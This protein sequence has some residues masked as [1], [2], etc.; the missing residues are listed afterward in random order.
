MK[1]ILL[2][3]TIILISS[4][5]QLYAQDDLVP[6]FPGAGGHGKY[7]T[8][9]RGGSIYYVTTLE[10]NNN[11]GS[12]RYGV[13]TLSGKRTILFKVSGNIVLKSSLRITKGDVT[14]AGQSAP[15]DGICISGFPVSVS[16]DNVIIRY[17]RFRMGD[18]VIPENQA[19]G[20]DAL[21]GRSCQNV[22]IDHCS[23]SWCIDECASFYQNRDFTM[24]WCLVTESMRMSKH[25]KGP[26]GY[27]GIWGGTRASF[28]HNMMAHHD[29]RNPRFGPGIS[30]DP[31]PYTEIT[32][33]R[34]NVLYNWRGN[35]A[36]GGEGMAVNM[37]NNYHKPGPATPTGSKRGR[38]VSIDKS[39]DS[40]K[41]IYDVWG[42]FYIEGNVID[43]G[44]NDKNCINA[45]NDNWT[46]GVYN[47]IASG[48]GT[49]T[50]TDKAEMKATEPYPAGEVITHTAIKAYEKVLDY[51]GASYKRDE[52]DARIIKETR[53]GTTTFKGS[54]LNQP[55]IIDSQRDLKPAGAGDDWSAWPE[56]L[57]GEVPLDSDGDGIP[58]EWE[59]ANGLNP[60]NSADAKKT[61]EEGYTYL[62]VYLNSIVEEITTKQ[63][64]D[65]IDPPTS[66]K[67]VKDD[68]SSVLVSF[69]KLSKTLTVS[70]DQ[71]IT[72]IYIWNVTGSL[73]KKDIYNDSFC[74]MD[75][76][77][78]QPGSYIIKTF[79][80]GKQIQIASKIII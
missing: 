8:G 39:S 54:S 46:Y 41:K 75:L 42:R 25:S 14:I 35:A 58:N 55:G 9:G 7:T 33:M 68:K 10:D 16:A 36:Y 67:L 18:E 15:G 20:A 44:K 52:I 13:S 26:H 51:V 79:L 66:I 24:Q 3:V 30:D 57:Q 4:A 47:Q 63:Y 43:D 50:A 65:A 19:D 1:Q 64:E 32:D 48:Y 61:N 72:E 12:L 2:F 62:E 38:I 28:H 70:S 74:T 11:T 45:T 60:Y 78:L 22:I 27:G 59:T 80:E 73:V 6:A 21:G 17:L 5:F 34:N 76:S 71:N 56:L 23:V 49:I 69:D 37:I 31:A 53:T 77:T 40:S 29:S